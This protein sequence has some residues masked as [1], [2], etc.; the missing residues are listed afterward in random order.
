MVYGHLVKAGQLSGH[1]VAQRFY[2]IGTPRGLK[3]TDCM[4][5]NAMRS[6][7]SLCSSRERR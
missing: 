6:G 1:E 5:T 4:L 3:E 7:E 2:E